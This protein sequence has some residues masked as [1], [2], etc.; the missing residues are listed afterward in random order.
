MV[1]IASRTEEHARAAA[2]KFNIPKIFVGDDWKKMITEENLDIVSICAPNYLH[3]PILSEAIKKNVHILCEKP[4]CISKKELDIIDSALVKKKA[5]VFFTA[6]HKRYVSIFPIVKKIVEEKVLGDITLVRHIFAHLGPYKSHDA[7]SKERWFFDSNKAGGGVLLDL[8][9]H[10]IDLF[11]YLVC[12]YAKV[13]GASYNT[14]C[15]KMKDEDSSN[16]LFRLKNNALG[17]ISV[18]WC[19]PPKEFLE[20]YGTK[21]S[22]AIDLLATNLFSFTPESLKKEPLIQQ[23]ISHKLS[24]IVPH[25]ALIDHFVSCVINKKVDHPNFEDGKKAVEFVLEAYKLKK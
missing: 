19:S 7:L 9:V 15:I 22:V 24:S 10:S 8:G 20:I 1:A 16:V 23:A 14:S 12:E 4:I 5:L 11:R 25:H 21:G 17:V 6:F 2:E 3:A 18:S 13:E